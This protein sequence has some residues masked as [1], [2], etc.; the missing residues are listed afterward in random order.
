MVF[1][2]VGRGEARIRMQV[3]AAHT[4]DDIALV[5]DALAHV[6]CG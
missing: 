6:A 2:I 4:T 3:S 1:P 5:L